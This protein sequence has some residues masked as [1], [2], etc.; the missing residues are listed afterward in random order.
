MSDQGNS[1]RLRGKLDTARSLAEAHLQVDPGLQSVFL[2][3]PLE[4]DNPHS[5]IKLLEVVEGTLEGDALP[6]GFTADPSRGID[7]PVQIVE[8]SPRE[9]RAIVNGKLKVYDDW[10]NVGEML[11]AR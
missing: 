7:Y 4:E 2:L 9:Y 11:V 5:P 8:I 1:K 6:V 3:E 10:W